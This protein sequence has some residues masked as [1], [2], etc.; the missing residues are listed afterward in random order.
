LLRF[1]LLPRARFY[2]PVVGLSR[3]GH[4]MTD[5]FLI[6]ALV[7]TGSSLDVLARPGP[8]G[9]TCVR[10]LPIRPK[11]K[12]SSQ[13]GTYMILKSRQVV[14]GRYRLFVNFVSIPCG[15]ASFS[16]FCRF[17]QASL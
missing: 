8:L 10:L 5:V 2:S 9:P 15:R 17:T 6:S 16:N 4:K 14:K 11:G 7:N 1:G 12:I 3:S 13:F